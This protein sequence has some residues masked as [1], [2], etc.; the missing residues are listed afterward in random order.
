MNGDI[1]RFGNGF[2][3]RTSTCDNRRWCGGRIGATVVEGATCSG[4][5]AGKVVVALVEGCWGGGY[6]VVVVGFTVAITSASHS[7]VMA[8]FREFSTAVA[9]TH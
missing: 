3:F 4:C 2:G 9:V 8:V 6:R 7:A 5:A 1:R